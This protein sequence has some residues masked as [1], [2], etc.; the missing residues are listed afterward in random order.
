MRKTVQ[1][2]RMGIVF[3][4]TRLSTAFRIYLYQTVIMY[5]MG[6][7]FEFNGRRNIV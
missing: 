1:P 5:E 3:H 6:E 4:V 2:F 7:E